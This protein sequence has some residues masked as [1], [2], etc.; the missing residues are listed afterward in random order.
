MSTLVSTEAFTLTYNV[1]D[2]GIAR[3]V[4]IGEL[5]LAVAD[6]VSASLTQRLA[7]GVRE[8]LDLSRLE[9]IDSTGLRA[10]I[11]VVTAGR[12]AGANLVE[13]DRTLASQV[14]RVIDVAG[15]GSVL[16]PEDPHGAD[17]APGRHTPPSARS[18]H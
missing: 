10:L 17:A 12:A 4:M 16:W 11:T 18:H 5:D 1:G 13:V 3:L 9:F 6:Q 7:D 8:R 2:D 15:V 14:R